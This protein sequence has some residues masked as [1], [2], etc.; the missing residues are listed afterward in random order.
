MRKVFKSL[1]NYISFVLFF[2]FIFGYCQSDFQTIAIVNATVI[3]GS[4]GEPI[5]NSTILIRN[6]SIECVGD[7]EIPKNA[8]LIDATSK[9]VIPGLIDTHV[10]YS[11]NG[12]IDSFPI[13]GFVPDVSDDYPYAEVL[14]NLKDN[15]ERFHQSYLCS[16]VTS[17]FD[18]GGYPWIF[19]IRNQASNSSDS[20]RYYTTGPLL[21]FEERIFPNSL[22]D[23]FLFNINNEKSLYEGLDL[24]M[25]MNTDGINLHNIHN[26]PSLEILESRIKSIVYRFKNRDVQLMAFSKGLEEAKLAIK[27]G[28]KT[29]IYS[30]DEEL[31]DNEFLTL[32]KE[33]DITYVPT[34]GVAEALL[35]AQNGTLE[36]DQNYL[37]CL[38]ENTKEK[39]KSTAQYYN[40]KS[41]AASEKVNIIP[42]PELASIRKENLKRIRNKGIR[43]AMGSSAGVPFLFHGPASHYEM[44]KMIEAGLSTMEVIVASTKN[45]AHVIGNDKIGILKP[46][47]YA[48]LIILNEN[49]LKNIDNI[50]NIKTVIFKGKIVK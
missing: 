48:D 28:V 36:V 5:K 1:K 42:D 34:L 2:V 46:G 33:N 26:A 16:G 40:Q 21:S 3:D 11:T 6:Q 15:P 29:L 39:I 24:L 30:I 14:K 45:G 50:Q 32:A 18:T 9:F 49:P 12:W 7:C 25:K 27:L 35:N 17:V 43:I 20:P 8:K 19:D 22:A 31:V 37:Q 23:G 47:N 44:K 13:P 38:D 4:G 10:H 41:N